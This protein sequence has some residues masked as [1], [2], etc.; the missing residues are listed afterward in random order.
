M[1]NNLKEYLIKPN[2]KFKIVLKKLNKK[3]VLFVVDKNL[4]LL[5]SITDGDIRRFQINSKT[6]NIKNISKI[7]F[8]KPIYSYENYDPYKLKI[9]LS[10]KIKLIPIVNKKKKLSQFLMVN[11]LISQ[12]TA[13]IY[14]EMKKNM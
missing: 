10:D 9:K 3:R 13:L 7:Y 12:F 8:N 14:L 4:K 6:N 1:K 2:E 11:I 5:G